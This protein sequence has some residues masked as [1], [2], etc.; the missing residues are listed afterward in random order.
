VIDPSAAE[1]IRDLADCRTFEELCDY[2]EPTGEPL[3]ASGLDELILR[4]RDLVDTLGLREER[5]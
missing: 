5:P 2:D 1:L 3:E 4:A